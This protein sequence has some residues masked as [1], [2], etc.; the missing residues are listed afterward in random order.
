MQVWPLGQTV[1]SPVHMITW[2]GPSQLG[3]QDTLCT[4][5]GPPMTAQQNP[6][7]QLAGPRQ[8][9]SAL[10]PHEPGAWQSSPVGE[11]P[12]WQQT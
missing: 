7:G 5:S 9:T 8:E 11:L 2:S 6:P 1:S 10:L 3:W 4:M 12:L